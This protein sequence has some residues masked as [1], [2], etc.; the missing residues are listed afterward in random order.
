MKVNKI[1]GNP[2]SVEDLLDLNHPL[3]FRDRIIPNGLLMGISKPPITIVVLLSR[4]YSD[5]GCPQK[6]ATR[7][8]WIPSAKGGVTSGGI[9]ISLNAFCDQ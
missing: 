7:A 2:S 8:K 3:S 5:R 9:I 1:P 6:S 4:D